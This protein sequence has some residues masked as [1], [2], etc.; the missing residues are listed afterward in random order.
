[1]TAPTSWKKLSAVGSPATPSSFGSC[2]AATVSPTPTLTPVSVASEMLSITVPRRR[3]RA[4][5]RITPTSSVNIAS[6][7][8]GS[9]APAATP[10]ASRLDAVS[11]ATV[12]VVLIDSVR[13]PPSSTY[14]SI[15]T[16]HVYRPT[17]TGSSAIVAYAIAWG[18][19]T[20]PA[21]S[22]PTKS[23]A[24]HLRSYLGSHVSDG[25]NDSRRRVP[26]VWLPAEGTASVIAGGSIRQSG[27]PGAG[28]LG[29]EHEE[30][31]DT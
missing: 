25:T 3:T 6:S 21:A 7:P 13:D 2:P 5:S 31:D 17:S 26:L 14:T 18:T 19:T 16:M 15:G 10:A 24:S 23:L 22:P 11:V 20:A 4:T 28:D 27:D 9:A 30:Q 1:M 8:N 29:A 12:D